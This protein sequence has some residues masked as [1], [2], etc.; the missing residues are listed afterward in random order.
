[1]PGEGV[2]GLEIGPKCCERRFDVEHVI[3]YRFA[4]FSAISTI[5]RV[6]AANLLLHGRRDTTI[7]ISG[8]HRLHAQA[9]DHT[10]LLILR[11][12]DHNS[13]HELPGARPA[14]QRTGPR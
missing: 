5:G 14:L 7:P 6:N 4:E 9:P 1:M 8:A 13:V 2:G 10:T 3:G 12:G 11:E